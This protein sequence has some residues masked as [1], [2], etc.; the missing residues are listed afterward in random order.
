AYFNVGDHQKAVEDY[1]RC[2]ALGGKE[3]L[4]YNNRG[5][6]L[7]ALGRMAEAER[8]YAR[9][10]ELEDRVGHAARTGAM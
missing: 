5:N 1:T 4:V 9:A 2:I 8:D 3:V 6:A 7:T 10:K